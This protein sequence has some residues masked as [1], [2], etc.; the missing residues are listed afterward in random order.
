VLSLLEAVAVAVEMGSQVLAEVHQAQQ[1]QI[2]VQAL[3]EQEA[4][5]WEGASLE[6]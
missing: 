2:T 5:K 1:V 3:E 4:L 6:F